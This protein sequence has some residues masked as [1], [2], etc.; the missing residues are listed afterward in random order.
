MTSHAFAYSSAL[1]LNDPV[2]V[3]IINLGGI[4]KIDGRQVDIND[5]AA[6][7]GVWTVSRNGR[8]GVLN[9][10]K[11]VTLGDDPITSG[12]AIAAVLEVKAEVISASQ[13]DLAAWA[14]TGQ[15][16]SRVRE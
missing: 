4:W 6:N 16:S 10:S 5:A 13:Q 3:A 2:G 15:E 7:Q 11:N 8:R 9:L 14:R 1:S 12:A